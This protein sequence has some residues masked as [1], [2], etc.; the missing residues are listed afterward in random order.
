MKVVVSHNI[1]SI[2]LIIIKNSAKYLLKEVH[3]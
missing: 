1:A 2:L 3:L